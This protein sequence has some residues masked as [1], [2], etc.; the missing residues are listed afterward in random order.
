MVA[1]TGVEEGTPHSDG[2]G[3]KSR[4]LCPFNG[5]LQD[6]HLDMASWICHGLDNDLRASHTLILR[7]AGSSSSWYVHISISSHPSGTF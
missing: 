6:W 7:S 1:I 2:F 3:V 4:S 5:K